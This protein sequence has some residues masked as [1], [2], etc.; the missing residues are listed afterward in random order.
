MTLTSM[1]IARGMV[2]GTNRVAA[3]VW[4]RN[5][6]EVSGCMEHSG[7]GILLSVLPYTVVMGKPWT[8]IPTYSMASHCRRLLKKTHLTDRNLLTGFHF[9]MKKRESVNW[10]LVSF[11]F[12]TC[13]N[14]RLTSYHCHQYY[15]EIESATKLSHRAPCSR[16]ILEE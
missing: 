15:I 14:W 1:R 4:K 13:E 6:L 12:Q 9:Y 5:N 3:T 11:S 7:Q 8:L 10:T 16:K 2:V